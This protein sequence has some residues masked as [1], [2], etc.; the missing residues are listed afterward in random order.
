MTTRTLLLAIAASLSVACT[1][2]RREAY[3]LPGPSTVFVETDER[4]KDPAVHI[5]SIVNLSSDPV[6]VWS[7]SLNRCE[8]IK[9]PC[10]AR[11]VEL[12]IPPKGR[13]VAM[14]VEPASQ[15]HRFSYRFS[16]AWRVDSVSNTIV[17]TATPPRP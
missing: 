4:Q 7:I 15:A 10:E 9:Q 1:S 6:F 11:P 16:F 5:V 8:N 12:H 13:H 17:R 2:A 14:R 3:V